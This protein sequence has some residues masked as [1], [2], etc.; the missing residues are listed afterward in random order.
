MGDKSPTFPLALACNSRSAAGRNNEC[1]N[2]PARPVSYASRLKGEGSAYSG[3]SHSHPPHRH[4][5]ANGWR[6]RGCE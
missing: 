4:A 5:K 6:W 3:R 2:R 1:L